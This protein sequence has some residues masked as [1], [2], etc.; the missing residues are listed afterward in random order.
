[1][2]EIKLECDV[3]HVDFGRD[4][5][6]CS[7]PNSP[8]FSDPGEPAELDCEFTINGKCLPQKKSMELTEILRE[9]IFEIL[10]EDAEKI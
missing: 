4:A 2:T 7:D 6:A 1:M 9:E 8:R 3:I 5:P 10:R